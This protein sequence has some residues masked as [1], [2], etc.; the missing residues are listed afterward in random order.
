MLGIR[1]TC[2]LCELYDVTVEV[3]FREP[4]EDIIVWMKQVVE[5]ALGKDHQRR[6]PDCHPTMLTQVKIPMPPG[7]EGLIGG[8]THQ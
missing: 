1:Y 8:P 2:A 7:K 5:P 4:A 6:S 3:R